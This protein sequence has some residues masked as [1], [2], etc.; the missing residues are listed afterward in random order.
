KREQATN[1]LAEAQVRSRF[2]DMAFWTPAVVT[3]ARGNATVE[4][5]W[6]DNLTQWR[7][8]AVGTSAAAQVGSGET[9]VATKKDLLVRLQAPRFF[10]ERDQVVVS[11][12]VHNYLPHDVRARVRLDLEDL[13]GGGSAASAGEAVEADVLS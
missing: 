8:L 6:P 12:N 9:R 2:V 10:V 4:V 13:T 11:A 1:G 7:A 3:D 5:T